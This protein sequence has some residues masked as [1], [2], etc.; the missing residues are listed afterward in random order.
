MTSPAPQI[1]S[2]PVEIFVEIKQ[3]NKINDNLRVRRI[4]FFECDKKKRRKKKKK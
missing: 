4:E 1:P 2:I 3:L